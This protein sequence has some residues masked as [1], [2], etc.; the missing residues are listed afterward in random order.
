MGTI[1]LELVRNGQVPGA[2]SP[3]NGMAPSCHDCSNG[4][5]AR[6]YAKSHQGS[7]AGLSL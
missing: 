5:G 4:S 7:G 3:R 2:A 6:R 1:G